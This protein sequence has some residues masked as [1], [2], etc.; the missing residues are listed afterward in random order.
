[1]SF[2]QLCTTALCHDGHGSFVMLKRGPG[3][4][5]EHGRWS[6]VSGNL[7]FMSSAEDSMRREISEELGTEPLHIEI[8]GYRD[9][10][11]VDGA[12]S[13]HCVAL[14]FIAHVPADDVKNAEP[15]KHD[16]LEWFTL[17]TLPP[18]QECLSRFGDYLVKYR[19]IIA[20]RVF[21]YD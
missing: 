9:L 16:A 1:M 15:R 7:Q 20:G 13:P 2:V 12:D 21:C 4:R 19:S 3:C 18:E 5:N 14:D 10:F 17:V 8:L 11:D 6:L